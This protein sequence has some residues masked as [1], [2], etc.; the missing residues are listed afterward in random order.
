MCDALGIV[1]FGDN[2]VDIQGMSNYRPVAATSFLGRYRI[3]DFVLSNMTNSGISQIQ[4]Y[5]KNRP[6]SLI[7]HVQES[8]FNINSKRGKLHI[9]YGENNLTQEVYNHD[10]NSF[11]ANMEFIERVDKPYVVIAPSHMIYRI[12]FNE[13]L[14]KH[15]ADKSDITVIYKQ[16]DEAKTEF[17]MSDT[18]NFDKDKRVVSIEKNRGKYKTRNV[19]LE[20]YVMTKKLFIEL[21]NRATNTS[22]LFWLKDIIADSCDSLVIRGYQH[23]G[24][25]ACINSLS[26]Y[27]NASMQLREYDNAKDLFKDDWPIHTKTNDSCPTR[28]TCTAKVSS[29]IIANGCEIAGTVINSVIGRNVV[30]KEGAVIE[31]CVILPGAYIGEGTKIDK[32][33]IDR[34][35]IV[36]HVKK[37]FGTKD[38]PIYVK[39]RDRI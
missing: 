12:D 34:F 20:G 23:K 3:I 32:C 26:S 28:Y 14:K 35:A 25:V 31:N 6:R 38:S 24:Y 1:N 19:S 7:D 27:Y 37:L 21:V 36:H 10:V 2:Y 16:T 22:S 4:V 5:I 8:N 9:L 39:R 30:V 13:V 29:S 17:F 18:L 15:I 33:V 11:M